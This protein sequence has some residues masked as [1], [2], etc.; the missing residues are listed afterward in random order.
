MII[1]TR[2]AEKQLNFRGILKRQIQLT[3]AQPDLIESGKNKKKV[4]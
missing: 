4:F 2:H 3:I 1:Y